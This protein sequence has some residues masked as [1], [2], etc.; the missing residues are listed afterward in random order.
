MKKI[1]LI[2]GLL[3]ITMLIM[4]LTRTI[5]FNNSIKKSINKGNQFYTSKNYDKALQIYKYGLA[6]NPEDPVLSYNAGQAAYLMG[7]YEQA[8]TY[9][10][11]SSD[12]LDKYLNLGNSNFKMQQY[13]PA[14]EIYK[15]G[16]LKFP[17]NIDL[18]YNYEFVKNK[19]EEQNKSNENKQDN[20]KDK[21]E[22]KQ[23]KQDNKND[24]DNQEKQ[25]DK[26]DQDNQDKQDNKNDQEN[27]D[28]KENQDT[29]KNE[30]E[31]ENQNKQEE[32]ENKDENKDNSSMN[33]NDSSQMKQNDKE[34]MQVL[35]MLEKQEEDSL[36]N[37]QEV[38]SRGK[39]EKY[40]W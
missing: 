14:L 21:Q 34:I 19:I 31:N 40:D 3:I 10:N 18:K 12:K 9:Y 36:K 8:I 39:E 7:D 22:N 37:N 13:Q 25:D 11:K 35:E 15:E 28:K 16:I 4:F 29:K 32:Q 30:E 24:Q 2:S 23:D 26:N 17:Q 20:N 5:D 27:Q 6:E 38:K 33:E 1:S